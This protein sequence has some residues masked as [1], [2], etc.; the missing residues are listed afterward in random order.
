MQ[1]HTGGYFHIYNRSNGS[2]LVFREKENYLYFLRLYRR[3]LL[4]HFTTVAYCL[5]PTH[6]H[7]LVRVKSE[8]VDQAQSAVGILLSS[9][10]KAINHRHARHGSLFQRHTKAK[11]VD[12]ERY[13]LTLLTY[14]HQNP[15]RAGLMDRLE[16]WPFSSYPDLAG[17]REGSL[18]DRALIATF[19]PRIEEMRAFSEAT[20]KS[21][22][23]RY[24]V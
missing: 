21:I 3:H 7:L 4:Q 20:L 9:Y 12:D 10:T 11:W 13:L 16:G 8:A 14:I 17:Y 18:C 24:W 23:A 15:I 5:M 2:E 1:L 19:F 6:F 22:D